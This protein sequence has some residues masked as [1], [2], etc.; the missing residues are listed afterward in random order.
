MFSPLI[1]IDQPAADAKESFMRRWFSLRT[2]C[3]GLA[4]L[5]VL[6]GI[7]AG[8]WWWKS[9]PA[10]IFNDAQ[11]HYKRGE[12]SLKRKDADAARQA[13]ENADERLK[14]L[15]AP[16]KASALSKD[17]VNRYLMLRY[18]VLSQLAALGSRPEAAGRTFPPGR[19]PNDL[20]RDARACA[21]LAAADSKYA[22][23]QAAMLEICF[24]EDQLDLAE[25]YA[26]NLLEHLP[27]SLADVNLH[28]HVMGAH[29]VLARQALRRIPPQPDETLEHVRVSDDLQK[30]WAD[31]QVA[32][33]RPRSDIRTRWR[34]INLQAQ[35][36]LL[37]MG[38]GSPP[39]GT[40]E[41]AARATFRTSVSGWLDRLRTDL[42][43]VGSDGETSA[44]SSLSG[45]E[46][47]GLLDFLALAIEQAPLHEDAVQRVRLTFEV[48]AALVVNREPTPDDTQETAKRTLALQEV[49]R[50]FVS[51][52]Q[53]L[54]KLPRGV[55]LQ[56]RDWLTIYPVLESVGTRLLKAGVGGEPETFLGLA[57]LAQKNGHWDAGAR[58]ADQGLRAAAAKRLSPDSPHV[59]GLH[60]TSA[61]LSL[62]QQ[63]PAEVDAHLEA[64]HK[65][66]HHCWGQTALVE[67]T[68]ALEEGD[69]EKGV[70]HLQRVRQHP[71]YGR[72]VFF[73]LLQ[74]HTDLAL[75][76]YDRAL[77]HLQK[78]DQFFG[79]IEQLT[80]EQRTLANRLSLNRAGITL[81]LFRCQLALGNLEQ[82]LLDKRQLEDEPEWLPERLTATVT[83]ARHYLGLGPTAAFLRPLGPPPPTRAAIGDARQELDAVRQFAPHDSRILLVEAE[84]LLASQADSSALG[85]ADELLRAATSDLQGGDEPKVVWFCWLMRQGRLAEAGKVLDRL[86]EQPSESLQRRLKILH[87][88]WSLAQ[89]SPLAEANG[90]VNLLGLW[91]ENGVTDVYLAG[92]DAA[93]SR[94]ES[95]GL[96]HFRRGQAAQLRGDLEVAARAYSQAMSFAF[97]RAPARR[98]LLA[99]LLELRAKDQPTTANDLISGTSDTAGFLKSQ[100]ALA[101]YDQA[102]SETQGQYDPVLLVAFIE[103]ALPLD[104]IRGKQ[105]VEQA[106]LALEKALEGH[107]RDPAGVAAY[108]ARTWLA[109]NRP[110]L[111]L[112]KLRTALKLNPAHLP[113][114]QLAAAITRASQDWQFSLQCADTLDKLQPNRPD[115]ALWRAETLLHLRDTAR[116]RELYRKF[117]EQYPD[118]SE[119]YQGVVG[120]LES[121]KDYSAAL[122]EVARWRSHLPADLRA[123]QAEVRLLARSGRSVQAGAAADQALRNEP[124][125]KAGREAAL[126]LAV[127]R[128]FLEAAQSAEALTWAGRAETAAARVTDREPLFEARCLLGDIS[129][130]LVRVNR[131]PARRTLYIEQAIEHY[132]AVFQEAPHHAEA[133][134]QLALLQA[135]EKHDPA[136]AFAIAQH[137]RQGL[138]SPGPIS[139]DRLPLESLDALGKVYFA[140]GHH[141]EAI[142]LF[143]EAAESHAE[144]PLVFLHLGKAQH[145]LHQTLEANGNLNR[146]AA[147]AEAKAA[148]ATDSDEKARWLSFATEAR[149]ARSTP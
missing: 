109:A 123:L 17:D 67:A 4:A 66:A 133:C 23:A 127:A 10:Q 26:R 80:E 48:W 98:H 77:P 88:V 95:A 51:W 116:A 142:V 81:E 54:E 65:H 42:K 124:T 141:A 112:A 96:K 70:L 110:D 78:L 1:A 128:G 20:S 82:A 76:R 119:G 5:V 21:Y 50:R 92:W 107:T 73:Y 38:T 72:S 29:F 104:N 89:T 138:Y 126:A 28:A 44:I 71:V 135:G 45:T 35:A 2:L 85:R 41:Q 37:K 27:D 49:N 106:L 131:E 86:K 129:R 99:C 15:L 57:R 16:E 118:R 25:R 60:A 93:V 61:W 14:V 91:E 83:L 105:G 97:L 74:A 132:R 33:G 59:L 147:L 24:R 140:S 64:I 75:G 100:A 63:K 36:L 32:D 94:H 30:R 103:I 139:G 55:S 111:A 143:K 130:E 148:R 125:G 122:V 113:S 114:L 120:L 46:V 102:G 69:L 87:N 137:L 146:A 18:R 144:E 53:V 39:G 43:P 145:E 11:G 62:L 90:L 101:R 134:R 149:S 12:E 136:A 13:F 8:R 79:K 9:R 121:E 7:F 117:A 84:W 108:Q 22:E 52:P 3:Y 47:R 34:M 115:V 56:S 68:K 58:F 40:A 6:G 31:A 19:T